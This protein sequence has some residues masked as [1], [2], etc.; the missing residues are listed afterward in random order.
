MQI[1]CF[2]PIAAPDARILIL[3]SMPGTASLGANQYYAH[4][5]NA[6]WY[7]MGA[8]FDAGPNKLY[9]KRFEI[10]KANK[11]ALWDV[12]STCS[13][14]GSLD[15]SIELSTI[16]PNDFESFFKRHPFITNVFFNGSKAEEIFRRQV[17]STISNKKLNYQKLPST[18]PANASIS[19]QDKLMAWEKSI[20]IAL[21]L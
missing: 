7:I 5:R 16:V 13:R 15:S 19:F 2:N 1:Q 17:I 21:S 20:K 8:I 18:S 11:V 4:P 12:L 3:G 9:D 14:K 10:L 6:F